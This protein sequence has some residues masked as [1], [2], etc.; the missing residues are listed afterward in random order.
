[1]LVALFIGWVLFFAYVLAS[2]LTALTKLYEGYWEHIPVLQRLGESRRNQHQAELQ[3]LKNELERR[4]AEQGALRQ[5][6]EQQPPADP[7]ELEAL[8]QR[9]KVVEAERTALFEEIYYG[10]PPIARAES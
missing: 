8:K 10:F 3:F 5:Q 1:F 2:L 4:R 9:I 7:N 6:L